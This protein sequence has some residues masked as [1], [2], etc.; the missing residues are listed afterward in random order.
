MHCVKVC[1]QNILRLDVPMNHIPVLQVEQCLDHLGDYMAG[2]VLGE[3]LL[4]AQLLIE[5]AMLAVLEHDV[6]VL[7]IVKVAVQAD[8][9][10][11]VKSPLDLKLTFHLAKEV[12]LL[13][14]ALEDDFQS[15]G[16]VSGSLD[17]LE[18]FAKLATADGLDAREVVHRPAFLFLFNIIVS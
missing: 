18:Y 9:I 17:S 16:H 10:R 13:Q 8:N 7:R 5:V 6:D 11:V 14:H 15:A 2:T 1:N 3:A 4:T 12:K